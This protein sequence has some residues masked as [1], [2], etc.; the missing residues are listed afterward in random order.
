MRKCF[1]VIFPKKLESRNSHLYLTWQIQL[2]SDLSQF[3]DVDQTISHHDRSIT[4]WDECSWM[5]TTFLGAFRHE[6]VQRI[7][8][9]CPQFS[10]SSQQGVLW[11]IINHYLMLYRPQSCRSESIP[12]YTWWQLFVQNPVIHHNSACRRGL[13]LSGRAGCDSV[14]RRWRHTR[15]WI[16]W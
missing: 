3:T 1:F 6:Y 5:C 4:K 11:W 2:H 10:T 7:I 15:P 8:L 14:F 16:F 13:V 9:L 12:Q